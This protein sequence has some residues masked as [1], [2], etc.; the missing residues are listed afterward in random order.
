MRLV[1]I[2]SGDGTLT[3][4]QFF[5]GKLFDGLNAHFYINGNILCVLFYQN[6]KKEGMEKWFYPN[7]KLKKIEHFQTGRLTSIQNF[8]STGVE[9]NK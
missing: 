9:L 8:D 6:G 4:K 7:G 3:S 2:Y 5:K 1:M